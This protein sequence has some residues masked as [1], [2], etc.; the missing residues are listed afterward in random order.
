MRVASSQYQSNMNRSLQLNQERI[1]YLTQQMAS[2]QRIQ[3]PSDDPVGSVRLSRLNREETNVKQ[4]RANITA[5]QDRLLK[6]QNYLSSMVGDMAEG[7]DL[8]IWASDGSNTSSDL[9]AMITSLTSQRDSMF[10]TANTKDQEGHYLFSGTATATPALK[11]DANAALGARYSFAGNTAAQSV[12]VSNGITQTANDNV[13]GLDALLNLMDNTIDTLSKQG[14]SPNDP[15]VSQTLKDNIDGI[16]TAMGLISNKIAVSGAA[17]N[18]LSTLDTN[19][20][21]V[22]LSNKM[23]LNNIGQL[24]YGVAATDLSGYTTALQSTYKAYTKIANLSLFDVL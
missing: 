13:Q 6:N 24:D 1:A 14:V 11:Y 4:Y 17:Q 21:N 22:S 15:T 3:L 2:G 9:N 19:H 5:L 18:I 20:G 16:D 10:Y 23:A 7:R 8:L 12:V